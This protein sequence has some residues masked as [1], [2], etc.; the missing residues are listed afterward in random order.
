MKAEQ[1]AGEPLP[2]VSRS[3]LS[4]VEGVERILLVLESM[5]TLAVVGYYQHLSGIEA[6]F[7]ARVF[8]REILTPEEQRMFVEVATTSAHLSLALELLPTRNPEHA[9]DII[10]AMARSPLVDDRVTATYFIDK[11]T[12]HDHDS[13]LRLWRD[14]LSDPDSGVRAAAYESLPDPSLDSDPE[15]LTRALAEKG[16]TRDELSQLRWTHLDHEEAGDA[17]R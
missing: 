7:K 12:R 4:E 14:L 11:L 10:S 1:P 5:P 8:D 13:G 6:A 15:E 16:L 17:Q 3:E 9:R 2:E